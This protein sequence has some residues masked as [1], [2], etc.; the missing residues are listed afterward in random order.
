M[1]RPK[2][3]LAAVLLVAVALPILYVASAGP[4]VYL[5]C[6][7]VVPDS[8]WDTVYAPLFTICRNNETANRYISWYMEWWNALGDDDPRT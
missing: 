7:G 8:A 5:W 2:R 3:R 1:E 6:R 4:A